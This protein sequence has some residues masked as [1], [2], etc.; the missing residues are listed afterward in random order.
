MTTPPRAT[1][2]V[3]VAIVALAGLALAA[4][5]Y[6]IAA[7]PPTRDSI[8]PKCPTFTAFGVHCP[9]CGTGRAAHFLL[10]GRPLDAVR[11][12]L[13][14]PFL[15][16]FVVV[17]T[18]RSL[19]VWAFDVPQPD[20]RPVRAIWLRLLAAALVAYGVLRNIPVEPFSALAP[21]EVEAAPAARP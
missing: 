6:V 11:A 12:N 4:G 1:R 19:L 20:G 5:V 13:F 9:G 18:F 16:P 3:R 21:K 15:L 2:V 7:T 8:Y 17:V 14:A 10:T